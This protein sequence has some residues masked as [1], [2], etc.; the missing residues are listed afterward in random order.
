MAAIT[1]PAI[2]K[3]VE[4]IRLENFRHLPDSMR[5]VALHHIMAGGKFP[6]QQ[7]FPVRP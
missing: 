7:Q 3:L 4:I 5:I 6:G 1:P 2:A